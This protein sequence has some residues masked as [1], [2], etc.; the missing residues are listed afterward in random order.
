MSVDEDQ[1]ATICSQAPGK[2][3]VPEFPPTAPRSDHDE[4]FGSKRICQR[5]VWLPAQQ[6]LNRNVTAQVPREVV[7][8]IFGKL[9]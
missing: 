8:G 3:V 9:D 7:Q 5:H 4:R 2:V 6:Y 1:V